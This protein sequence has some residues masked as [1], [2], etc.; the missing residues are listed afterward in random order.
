[1][2]ILIDTV[3]LKRGSQSAVSAASLER[4]EPAV[5]LDTRSMWVGDG[6][7]KIK[8]SDIVVVADYASLPGTGEANKLYLVLTDEGLANES[9]L[10][11]FKAA[12]Y[13]LV[14]CGTGTL[15]TSDITGF[16]TDVNAVI[17]TR[18]GANDG[19]APLDTGG[20]IPNSYLPDLSITDVHVVADN[21]AR[22]ALSVQAGDI[23]IV[24]GTNTT[25]IYTGSVWQE[26][27]TAPDGVMQVNGMSGP[28]VT[29]TTANI[30]ENTNLYFTDARA[31][32]AVI[33]DTATTGDTDLG[34]SANKI[35]SELAA[36]D[37][38]LGT[39]SIDET[40]IGDGKTITYNS[41]SGNM[42]YHAI[43]V[44]GGD[45]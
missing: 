4:G 2:T 38:V 43:I 9:S 13:V 34:W 29:L 14:T 26:M 30:T 41:T 19:I 40:N 1:M 31:K 15:T 20:K 24:T 16:T 32:A 36:H 37:S 42:E 11:V 10:Y 18:R 5:A 44:D 27:L 25:Y 23:A 12:Q 35:E 33:D 45:L 3:K 39:K 6:T 21:S 22:D 28:N 17:N 8:I 7:G